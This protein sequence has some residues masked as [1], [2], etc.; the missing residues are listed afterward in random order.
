MWYIIV[1]AFILIMFMIMASFVVADA[2]QRDVE[3]VRAHIAECSLLSLKD[4]SE[5]DVTFFE[6]VRELLVVPYQ[7]VSQR[8]ALINRLKTF[9]F[10]DPSK[11]QSKDCY[12]TPG[13]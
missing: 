7:N 2:R 11:A 10:T 8:N 1:P 6:L 9:Q 3:V 13:E 12:K 5:Q 4:R